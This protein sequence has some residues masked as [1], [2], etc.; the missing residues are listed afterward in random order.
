MDKFVITS[1]VKA[2]PSDL[3]LYAIK[4][5]ILGAKYELSV[6]FI[7]E[8]RAITLN[9]TYRQKSYSPNVLSFPLTHTVGEIFITP[10]V[11]KREAPSYNLTYNGYISY[12][13]IHGC[14]HLKGIDHGD[15]MDKLERKYIK[16]FG[17][18]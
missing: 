17:I 3:S 15:T 8:K 10:A 7:G 5:A 9:Q 2:F 11:A 4:V 6:T 13:F 14:L 1:T 18:S 16:A 12:L